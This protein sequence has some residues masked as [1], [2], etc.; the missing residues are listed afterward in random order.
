MPSPFQ[1]DQGHD[2][3]RGSFRGTP[4]FH[5]DHWWLESAIV[6]VF[7]LLFSFVLGQP[8]ELIRFFFRGQGGWCQFCHI[9]PCYYICGM[10]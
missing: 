1:G 8:L 7:V 6:G 2:T 5:P 10:K 4:R 3:S 9:S